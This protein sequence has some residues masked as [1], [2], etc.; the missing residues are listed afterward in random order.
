MSLHSA[1]EKLLR[2]MG[3]PVSNATTFPPKP[4]SWNGQLRM[5]W[6]CTFWL[7]QQIYGLLGRVVSASLGEPSSLGKKD[8][9]KFE[10]EKIELVYLLYCAKC[11][12]TLSDCC[13]F[14]C[15]TGIGC[16]LDVTLSPRLWK[17]V[18]TYLYYDGTKE[19]E[20]NR[21][22]FQFPS[23]RQPFNAGAN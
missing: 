2:P 7:W 6:T 13:F 20:R 17:F 23:G 21:H 5:G 4:P 3:I 19:D 1:M 9:V 14:L 8:E 18:K 12:K 10:I 22:D 16:D 15:I 11:V